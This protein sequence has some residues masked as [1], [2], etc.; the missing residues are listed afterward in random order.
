MISSTEHYGISPSA[1]AGHLLMTSHETNESFLVGGHGAEGP[2]D[3]I[4]SYADGIWTMVYANSMAS[5]LPS[6]LPRYETAGS[7]LS[8]DI[9][10]FAGMTIDDASVSIYNDLW[11]FTLSSSSKR[12]VQVYEEMPIAERCGHIVESVHNMLVIHGG[13]CNGQQFDDL[14]TFDPMTNTWLPLP[15]TGT[16]PQMRSN[17]ASAVSRDG[18][19]LVLC[20][21]LLKSQ[22][23]DGN[24][25]VEYLNDVWLLD[26]AQTNP[27]S[28]VWKMVI[29]TDLA[30]SPRDLPAIIFH[31]SSIILFGGFGLKEADRLSE[32]DESGVEHDEEIS[33]QV[34]EESLPSEGEDSSGSADADDDAYESVDEDERLTYLNDIWIIHT[35]DSHYEAVSL[36]STRFPRPPEARGS[37]LLIVDE[38]VCAFGGYDGDTDSF[39][40]LFSV[41][42]LSSIDK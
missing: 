31:G 17:H 12:W 32:V 5:H 35:T 3:D 8:G 21:G 30:P 33:A 36:A 9:F 16:K 42:S 11:R 4:W 24:D 40:S 37:K 10:L 28:W 41:I 2:F 23:E 15:M 38:S 14:I 20:G 1:R 7:L 27:K 26:C 25:S 19:M 29:A 13:E 22:D 39:H 6:P 18:N 34:A